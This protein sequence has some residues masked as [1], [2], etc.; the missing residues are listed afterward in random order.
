MD[1][2]NTPL[3]GQRSQIQNLKAQ[4]LGDCIVEAERPRGV[5]K[6]NAVLPYVAKKIVAVQSE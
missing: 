5:K 4:R 2:R 6:K 1:C 3:Q